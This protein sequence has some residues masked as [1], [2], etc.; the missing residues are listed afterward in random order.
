MAWDRTYQNTPGRTYDPDDPYNLYGEDINE[1]ITLLKT[2]ASRHGTGGED[3]ITPERTLMAAEG[4]PLDGSA[5]EA[6]GPTALANGV[7]TYGWLF[8]AD[9][10]ET[11]VF[12]LGRIPRRWCAADP[13][14]NVEWTAASGSGA[15]VWQGELLAVGDNIAYTGSFGTAVAIAADTLQ[16]AGRC[17]LTQESAALTSFPNAAAGLPA[18]FKLS[19]LA[20]SGSDTLA[21][22][23]EFRSAHLSFGTVV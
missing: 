11:L 14:F 17:H 18:F 13:T 22:D 19:R 15:V 9:V 23:A 5:M 21:V 3:P 2:H 12:A 20:T 1:I 8:D 7:Y 4:Y 16:T 6:A 10:V